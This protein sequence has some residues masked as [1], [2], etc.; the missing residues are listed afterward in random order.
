MWK[1]LKDGQWIAWLCIYVN[2]TL[3]SIIHCHTFGPMLTVDARY[4]R[5]LRNICKLVKLQRL[6][7]VSNDAYYKSQ[8]RLLCMV[9]KEWIQLTWNLN[10]IPM[11]GALFV[12]SELVCIIRLVAITSDAFCWSRCKTADM[13]FFLHIRFR[14]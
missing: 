2:E 3:A 10:F 14:S 1:F 11:Y 12:V 6:C 9:G 4:V 5:F 8:R 7:R 13:V